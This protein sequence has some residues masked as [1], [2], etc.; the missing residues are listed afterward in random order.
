MTIRKL[1]AAV[2][3]PA[4]IALSSVA[5][6]Q[7]QS[8]RVSCPSAFPLYYLPI[9]IADKLG[10]FKEAGLN[11]EV[12]SLTGANAARALL[13]GSL[14]FSCNSLDHAIK[15]FAQ[16][17]SIKLILA[18]QR[19]P[20]LALS[21]ATRLKGSVHDVRDLKGKTIGIAVLGSSTHLML[22]YLIAK[23]GMVDRDFKIVGV[24]GPA[25]VAAMKAGQ[26]DAGV[27]LEPYVTM[28][29]RDGTL[30]TV[31]D[32]R[33]IAGTKAV[34][35]TSEF[36]N[37]G[38]LVSGALIDKD[39]ALVQKFVNVLVKANGWAQS[40]TPR[41]IANAIGVPPEG[42]ADFVAALQ[43][44]ADAYYPDA[45]PTEEGIKQTVAFHRVVGTIAKDMPI[46]EQALVDLRFITAAQGK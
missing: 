38:V 37:T 25:F 42:Q 36:V 4:I 33:T 40:H 1:L 6:A 31:Q 18:F 34:M 39:P 10:L 29:E 9:P 45:I 15:A 8:I 14:E 7:A 21:V 13:A 20:G 2:L 16:G 3:L 30:H 27:M 35:G 32:F 24:P 43:K 17:Q 28:L 26:I 23:A 46:N 11:V 5:P 22:Q 12:V 41:E 44:M 19:L